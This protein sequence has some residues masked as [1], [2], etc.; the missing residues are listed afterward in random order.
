MKLLLD[1]QIPR[2]LS[3]HF[4]DE[5]TVDHVQQLGWEET[6]NGALLKLASSAGYDALI[7]A[8]KNMTYQQNE[9]ELPIS[10]VILRVYRL[11]LEELAPLIP[12]TL[13]RLK[14][15]STPAFIEIDFRTKR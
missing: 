11:K 15:L 9:H 3:R 4:P 13:T 2:R 8:D 10:V 1:E 14:N 5:F 7:S 12:E 6:K